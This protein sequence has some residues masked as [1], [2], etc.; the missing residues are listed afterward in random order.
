MNMTA[1]LPKTSGVKFSPMLRGAGHFL[2]WL[3][4]QT[5]LALGLATLIY[6]LFFVLFCFGS[7]LHLFAR[8]IIFSPGF[9]HALKTGYIT[10][11]AYFLFAILMYYLVRTLEMATSW[12][13]ARRPWWRTVLDLIFAWLVGLPLLIFGLSLQRS[14]APTPP[15][16]SALLAPSDRVLLHFGF[17]IPT[18]RSERNIPPLWGTRN[19]VGRATIKS[20]GHG[21]YMVQM[22]SRSRSAD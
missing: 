14:Y 15:K 22:L 19:L 13:T 6:G 1:P 16:V 2:I 5:A 17:V 9:V 12:I 7:V 21:R 11:A 18:S 20:L 4:N 3:A 8:A 10:I